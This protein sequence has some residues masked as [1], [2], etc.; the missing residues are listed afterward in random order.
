MKDDMKEKIL[1]TARELFNERGYN[2][3]S[4]R[5]IADALQISV[6]NLTYHFKRKEDLVEA[7]IVKQ[8]ENY[9]KKIIPRNLQELNILFK[10]LLTHEEKNS[11]YFRHYTQ[12][13]QLCPKVYEIQVEVIGDMNNLFFTVFCDFQ[14]QGLMQQEG[15]PNQIE[16]LVQAVLSMSIYGTV[17]FGHKRLPCI[18]SLIFPLLTEK[19]KE[20]Y[21]KEIAPTLAK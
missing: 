3:V 2:D 1:F 11:Y 20:I 12:L 13:A 10:D 9:K 17:P 14:K 4:M 18:W 8:H 19:G 6:G 5:N 15:I 21:F 7:V 16:Y